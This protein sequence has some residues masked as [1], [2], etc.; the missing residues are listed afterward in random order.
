LEALPI[1]QQLLLVQLRPSFHQSVL[2]SRQGAADPLDGVNAIN[3]NRVLVVG[4]EMGSLMGRTAL[5]IHPNHDP[6][7][8]SN[9]RHD[10]VIPHGAGLAST[11]L[12]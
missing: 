5:G 4:V 7:K 11:A 2:T 12:L 6:E 9:L 10:L 8:P 3:A 1:R